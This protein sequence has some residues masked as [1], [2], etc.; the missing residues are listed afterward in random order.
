MV[1]GVPPSV[2]GVPVDK[3]LK[4]PRP[5]DLPG[6]ATETISL[7]IPPTPLALADEVIDKKI[8]CNANVAFWQILLQKCL[9]REAGLCKR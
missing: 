7:E 5:S 4:V 1:A 9:V 2:C 3:I 6:R 8:C